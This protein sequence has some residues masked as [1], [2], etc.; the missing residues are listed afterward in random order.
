MAYTKQTWADLPSKTTPINASRLGHIEDGIYDAASVA[1]TAASNASSAIS[2]LADKVDKV[3]GKGLSTNDYDDTAK[4]IV[5]AVTTNLSTKVDK[6]DVARVEDGSSPSATI[7]A[8]EQFYHNNILYTATQDI[9]TT[10][11][12]TP[13]TNCRVSDS[14]T[15]QIAS[16][17]ES[18]Y[19]LVEDTVGWSGKNLIINAEDKTLKKGVEGYDRTYSPYISIPIVNGS[20][21]ILSIEIDT[22]ESTFSSNTAGVRIGYAAQH[23]NIEYF[24]NQSG[25]QEFELTASTDATNERL[26][27][28]VANTASNGTTLKFSK[29]MLRRADIIDSTYEPYHASVNDT[30]KQEIEDTVGWDIKN[31]FTAEGITTANYLAQDGTSVASTNWRITDYIDIS[32]LSKIELKGIGA[33]GNTPSLCFYDSNKVYISG[34]QY[35]NRTDIITVKPSNAVYI[36]VSVFVDDM[37]TIILT[38]ASV[39][40]TKADNSVIA[41]V[42]NQPTCQKSEGYAVG[43]HFIR[44]GKFCTVTAAIAVNDPLSTATNY[45]EGALGDVVHIKIETSA[46]SVSANAK[47]WFYMDSLIPFANYEVLN[48]SFMINGSGSGNYAV[49][50]W[51]YTTEYKLAYSVHNIDPT[52]AHS[53]KVIA[54]LTLKI[55]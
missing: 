36:R 10:D 50:A 24:K 3:E 32:D 1:D 37:E 54:Y 6:S 39:D 21:Y 43:E 47:S 15:S 52:D 51:V 14:V 19:Q 45:K 12:I 53:W 55:S 35:K 46:Q 2:G 25:V 27:V 5:D 4:G 30:I 18:A 31:Y 20:K 40:E 23:S 48:V 16:G 7:N 17:V 38:H 28:F 9:A 49:G 26:Y 29:L 42:E 34:V 11:T 44:N 8:D 33:N 41:P 13:N 22:A